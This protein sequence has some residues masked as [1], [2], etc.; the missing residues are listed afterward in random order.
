[1]PVTPAEV[2]VDAS[3][4][5]RGVLREAPDAEELLRQISEGTLN[6]HAP[7]LIAP[8]CTNAL[9]RLVRAGRLPTD[10]AAALL[11]VVSSPVIHRHA[12]AP[13][14]QVALDT[15]LGAGISGYDAFY[16]VLADALDCPLVTADRRLGEAI[17]RAVL[18]GSR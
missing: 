11:D 12:T 3:A 4:V 5:V 16:A 10:E 9:L 8:E 6:A 17:D 18:V 1:M 15:A 2:V 14:A 7:D 13:F